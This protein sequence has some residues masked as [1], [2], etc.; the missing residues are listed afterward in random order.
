MLGIEYIRDRY[1]FGSAIAVSAGLGSGEVMRL[2]HIGRSK[3]GL[4]VVH[5]EQLDDWESLRVYSQTHKDV[6]V[7][8]LLQGKGILL[9]SVLQS[10]LT[11]NRETDI[12]QVFP[13]YNPQDFYVL[14]HSGGEVC[15]IALI[16]RELL[17]ALVNGLLEKQIRLVEVSIGP[18][19]LDNVLQQLNVYNGVYVFDGH[20]IAT[21]EDGG[22]IGYDFNAENHARFKTKIGTTH[23]EQEYLVAYA[24][25]FHTLMGEF[26]R[27]YA[28]EQ[29]ALTI[30]M[31]EARQQIKFKNNSLLLLGVVFLLLII[32]TLFFSY[33]QGENDRLKG[34][35]GQQQFSGAEVKERSQA[36]AHYEQL[37]KELGWNGGISK[38]WLLD[39]LGVSLDRHVGVQLTALQ[40]NPAAQRKRGN[41]KESP[42]DLRNIMVVTGRCVSLDGL[43]TWVRALENTGW[44][45][46]LNM[47]RF[48]K[49]QAYGDDAHVFQ[50]E[51]GFGEGGGVQRS[52]EFVSE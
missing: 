23:I 1:S 35:V 32:S 16:R 48:G 28:L 46:R 47:V 33:Y 38:A 17:D 36:V 41:G 18:F 3:G 7:S 52:P 22:W 13:A 2:M 15:W 51:I 25:A 19:V 31:D 4:S 37:L 44:V 5:T 24:M 21:D 42:R 20:R 6:P 30:G 45:D 34:Q 40:I 11:N 43:N 14:L 9:K 26:V 39:Q 29:P 8:L 49:S 12:Q 50:L 27:S 10:Q